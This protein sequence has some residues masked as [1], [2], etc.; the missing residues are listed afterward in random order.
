MSNTKKCPHCKGTGKAFGQFGF[1]VSLQQRI[2]SDDSL[3]NAFVAAGLMGLTIFFT[4]RLPVWGHL[5]N[6]QPTLADCL[7][8]SIFVAC[9]TGLVAWWYFVPPT[10]DV[11][12]GEVISE[13]SQDK[14]Q[15]KVSSSHS[16][17]LITRNRTG[18]R[19]SF[20]DIPISD[21]RMK[22]VATAVMIQGGGFTRRWLCDHKK[23]MSQKQFQDLRLCLIRYGI[24]ESGGNRTKITPVGRS[25]FRYYKG[26][27][28]RKESLEGRF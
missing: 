13:S 7:E 10:A 19:W 12:D 5:L 14:Q 26:L 4:I 9:W 6:Q 23:V 20:I 3:F 28:M 16:L 2:S 21:S 22:E 1:N 18:G 24:L 15:S 25:L 11:Y 8:Y 27:D 17:E